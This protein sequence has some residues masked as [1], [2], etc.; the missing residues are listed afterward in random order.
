MAGYLPVD[1]PPGT[2][3]LPLGN[4]VPSKGGGTSGAKPTVKPSRKPMRGKARKPTRR[5]LTSRERR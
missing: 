2:S 4:G 1:T 5:P 3:P